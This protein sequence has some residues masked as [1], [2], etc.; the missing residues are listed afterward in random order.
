MDS[1]LYF[2]FASLLIAYIILFLIFIQ[3]NTNKS[4][5]V[6]QS[7]THISQDLKYVITHIEDGDT[8]TPN[9]IFKLTDEDQETLKSI[10]YIS[11][12]SAEFYTKYYGKHCPMLCIA[13]IKDVDL[14]FIYSPE[15]KTFIRT[16]FALT[17]DGTL[18]SIHSKFSY[19]GQMKWQ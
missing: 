3:K 1:F 10:G 16:D 5:K 13:S 14:L 17:K 8:F 12:N 6:N 9:Y 7:D 11:C 18:E 4:K 19:G 2:G 15:I